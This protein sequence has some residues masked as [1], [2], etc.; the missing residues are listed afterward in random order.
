MRHFP[1]LRVLTI[2]LLL[3]LTFCLNSFIFSSKAE[4]RI[5]P[6]TV[7]PSTVSYIPGTNCVSFT[8]SGNHWVAGDSVKFTE[9]TT[10]AYLGTVTVNSN[11]TFSKYVKSTCG[12]PKGTNGVF[13]QDLNNSHYRASGKFT[14]VS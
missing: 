11:G 3:C 12:V 6:L 5:G 14:V 1:R 13:A 8:A 9:S 4:A 7:K 10:R 2:A